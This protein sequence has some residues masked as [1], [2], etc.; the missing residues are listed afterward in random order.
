MISI[1]GCSANFQSADKLPSRHG[2]VY[3]RD[4]GMPRADNSVDGKTIC[5]PYSCVKVTRKT[6]YTNI[7]AEFN[8]GLRQE[9]APVPAELLRRQAVPGTTAKTIL[10]K[11]RITVDRRTNGSVA[12]VDNGHMGKATPLGIRFRYGKYNLP[13]GQVGLLNKI[14]RH[15]RKHRR[16]HIFIAGYRDNV[17]REPESAQNLLA[18]K[19]AMAIAR[20]LEAKGIAKER[21]HVGAYQR[22]CFGADSDLVGVKGY[23]RRAEIYFDRE[24]MQRD[25][26]EF[27]RLRAPRLARRLAVLV[28]R[29]RHKLQATRNTAGVDRKADSS[30]AESMKQKTGTSSKSAGQRNVDQP[31][32]KAEMLNDTVS[33][34]KGG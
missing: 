7:A 31:E 4:S 6:P 14:A 27:S 18:R 23:Y 29:R 2:S 3:E 9:S 24:K 28:Q 33:S 13:D 21:L 25:A 26:A 16:Q 12:S 30:D 22:C 19:R 5:D 17:S 11:R 34:R 10:P 32:Q 1:A 15:A 20:Y 8:N